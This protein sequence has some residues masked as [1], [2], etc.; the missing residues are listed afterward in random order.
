MLDGTID[1][2]ATDHAPHSFEEK[3][4]G[5][6]K[7]LM[8]ITGIETAFPVVYTKLVKPGILPLELVIKMLTDNPRN[9]FGIKDDGSLTIW[10]LSDEYK[11]D[12]N[13]FLSMGKATPSL[14]LYSR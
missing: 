11:I 4:K 1:M 7:S 12:T 6:E 13:D 3:S 8:G 5:L 14:L 10:D 2:L 9:R